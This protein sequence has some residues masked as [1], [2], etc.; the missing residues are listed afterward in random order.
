MN[1]LTPENFGKLTEEFL[2]CDLGQL[3]RLKLVVD[4][5]FEKAV[6][7][8]KYCR[9]YALLCRRLNEEAPNYEEGGAAAKNTTFQKCLMNKLQAEFNQ[10][11]QGNV[12]PGSREKRQLLGLR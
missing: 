8:S 5:I 9:L 2:D 11:R 6:D 4:L 3:K 7:E 12:E 1:K 10:R